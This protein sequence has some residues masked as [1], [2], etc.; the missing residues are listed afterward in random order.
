MSNTTEDFAAALGILL[1][2]YADTVGPTLADFPHG[3]RGYNTL[4]E[5]LRGQPPSQAALAAKLGI[6]RTMMTYLIDDLVAAG[7]V[8]RRTDPADRRQR[9]I[10]ATD[11]GRDA[12]GALC[13]RVAAAENTALGALDEEER[14][15]F[16]RL[17]SK[18]A[19]TGPVHTEEACEIVTEALTT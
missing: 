8:E 9:R 12:V 10:V 1:R 18:A 3:A 5:V 14:A 17:L 2:S 11:S 4:Y 6:D 19:G 13:G 7:L 15:A 16:R